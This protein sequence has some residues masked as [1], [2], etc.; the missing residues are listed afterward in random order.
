VNLFLSEIVGIHRM[1]P[2][3]PIGIVARGPANTREALASALS[4]RYDGVL[5]DSLP[6]KLKVTIA[7]RLALGRFSPAGDRLLERDVTLA[8]RLRRG[9]DLIK[10]IWILHEI[11]QK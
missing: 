8:A 4:R 3:A 6:Q 10:Q 9:P 1:R 2:A 5:F 11:L 7:A